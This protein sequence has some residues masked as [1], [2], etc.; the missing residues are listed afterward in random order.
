MAE[1]CLIGETFRPETSAQGELP[2][3]VLVGKLHTDSLT[4]PALSV[5]ERGMTP[6]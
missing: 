6:V 1:F 2:R 5:V 4:E 3:L